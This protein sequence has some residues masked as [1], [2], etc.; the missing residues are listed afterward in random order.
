[1]KPKLIESFTLQRNWTVDVQ[2]NEFR[3]TDGQLDV[4]LGYDSAGQL[5]KVVTPRFTLTREP[6]PRAG[7]WLPGIRP[8]PEQKLAAMDAFGRRMALGLSRVG[9]YR[10][11]DPDGNRLDAVVVRQSVLA[12]KGLGI[13]ILGFTGGPFAAEIKPWV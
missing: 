12:D 8:I 10:W 3:H 4:V 13:V 7:K 1:M 5:N 6:H 9:P 2:G 11:V